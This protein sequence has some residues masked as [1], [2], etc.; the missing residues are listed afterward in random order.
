MKAEE[1][2]ALPSIAERT[3]QML[4]YVAVSELSSC[5]AAT[6]W[7]VVYHCMILYVVTVAAT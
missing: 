2:G 6:C 1:H 4:L 7:D 3:G 5:R